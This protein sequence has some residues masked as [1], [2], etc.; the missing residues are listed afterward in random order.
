MKT[1]QEDSPEVVPTEEQVNQKRTVKMFMESS[2][3]DRIEEINPFTKMGR[4][5]SR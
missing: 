1:K 5:S 4:G 3:F 2:D